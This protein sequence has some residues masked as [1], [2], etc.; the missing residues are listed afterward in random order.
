[1]KIWLF[2][3][4]HLE[5]TPLPELQAPEADLCI[6]AGD[7]LDKGIIPSL[8]WLNA[9]IAS[10]MPVIFVAGNHEFYKSSILE[11]KASARA[12]AAQMTN[13]HY[14]ENQ[15]IEIDD[16]LFAGATLWT[17]QSLHDNQQLSAYFAKD[18]QIGMND[19]KKIN[20]QKSPWQR[21]TPA[22]TIGMHRESRAFIQNSL[23]SHSGKSVVITHHAPSILSMNDE[24]AKGTAAPSYASNM[25]DLIDELQPTYWV[26]GH[27]HQS[28]RY[29]IGKTEILS[30]PRGYGDN[31]KG[32]SFNPQFVFEV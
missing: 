21:L 12:A 13:V 7:I 9:N 4:L 18:K 29:K 8:D 19:Y 28:N 20:W 30:N 25:D 31:E 2:S 15:A 17:D 27:I 11:A 16:I 1:M 23:K 22:R 24:H 10:K 3:D 32:T 6:A 26:H 14:L 5:H